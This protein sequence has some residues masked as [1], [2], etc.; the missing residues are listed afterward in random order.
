MVD[1]AVGE[2]LIEQ[3]LHV[4]AMVSGVGLGGLSGEAGDGRLGA[5][6]KHSG[7]TSVAGG[8]RHWIAATGPAVGASGVEVAEMDVP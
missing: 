1:K 2:A 6:Q 5:R 3:Q 4:M 7:P 8:L